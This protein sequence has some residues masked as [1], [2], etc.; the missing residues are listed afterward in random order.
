MLIAT[1]GEENGLPSNS[2]LALI[3]FFRLCHGVRPVETVLGTA[4]SRIVALLHNTERCSPIVLVIETGI[5]R[6]ASI[7]GC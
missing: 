5:T 2:A 3:I 6:F 1:F 7:I 4:H